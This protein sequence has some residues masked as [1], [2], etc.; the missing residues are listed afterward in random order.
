MK[1]IFV[2]ELLKADGFYTKNFSKLIPRDHNP[3]PVMPN[4]T[5]NLNLGARIRAREVVFIFLIIIFSVSRF[6]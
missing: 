5:G 1:L 2:A 3:G 6:G 4:G